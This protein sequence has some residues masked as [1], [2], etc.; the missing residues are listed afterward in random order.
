MRGRG[1]VTFDI[2]LVGWGLNKWSSYSQAMNGF[3]Q[4]PLT[5]SELQKIKRL[6]FGCICCEWVN[7]ITFDIFLLGKGPNE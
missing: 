3:I 1:K 4:Y 2:F 7:L 6:I 5:L